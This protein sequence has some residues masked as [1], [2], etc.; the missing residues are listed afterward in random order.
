MALSQVDV[1]FSLHRVQG[2]IIA[3][4]SVTPTDSQIR[5]DSLRRDLL[6]DGPNSRRVGTSGLHTYFNRGRLIDGRS[7]MNLVTENRFGFGY[8][9]HLNWSRLARNDVPNSYNAPNFKK[10]LC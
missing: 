4:V 3:L 9:S 1:D 5:F 10:I 8:L 2:S 7:G 6:E